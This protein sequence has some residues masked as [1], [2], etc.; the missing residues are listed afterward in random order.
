MTQSNST[1]SSILNTIK[2]IAI[3]IATI[4][5]IGLVI[6]WSWNQFSPVFGLSDINILQ[7]IALFL[8][9]FSSV[10][11][12]SMAW[13]YHV[14]QHY[15]WFN[16]KDNSQGQYKNNNDPEEPFNE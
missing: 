16:W 4:G 6:C 10:S 14:K 1:L 5:I 13:N 12:V 15:I 3:A 9:V 11:V 8:L 2:D 7:A